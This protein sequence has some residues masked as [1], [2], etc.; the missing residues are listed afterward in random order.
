VRRV[1]FLGVL[2]SSLS[3]WADVLIDLES[4]FLKTC[5][6]QENAGGITEK[7]VRKGKDCGDVLE[8][9]KEDG[10][11]LVLPKKEV[12]AVLPMLP[13]P[14]MRYLQSDSER[15]LAV[16]KQGQKIYPQRPEVAP[17]AIAKW[18][19]LAAQKTEVDQFELSAL[20]AW[21]RSSGEISPQAK[22][23]EIKRLANEGE[24]F[25]VKFPHQAEK[26]VEQVKGLRD[27]S[28]IDLS[29]A[30]NLAFPLGSFGDNF[31]PGAILWG[32]LLIPL[33]F[34]IQGLAGTVQG[35]RERLPLAAT[36]RFLMALAGIVF[37]GVI[38]T[39][40][41]RNQKAASAESSSSNTSAQKALWLSHNM[42]EQWSDQ[43]SQR[44]TI[45]ALDW[46][47]FLLRT[48][49]PGTDDFNSLFWRLDK[50]N[51]EITSGQIILLQ[52]V[53]MKV[54]PVKFQFIFDVPSLGQAWHSAELVGAR[55]GMLPLGRFIGGFA[56]EAISHGFSL[57]R[58]GLGLD[59]GIRWMV[60]E[61][62]SLVID[63]PATHRQGPLPKENITA[64]ELAEVF[65][66]G[67]GDIYKDRYVNVEG[68]LEEVHSTHDTLG[69]GVISS[70]DPLDEFYL[71]GIKADGSR[72]RI[73]ICCKIK[74]QEKSYFLDGKGDLYFKE[75]QKKEV[76]RTS[77]T[78]A[79]SSQHS[80]GA[81]ANSPT[82]REIVKAQN[83]N[84]NQSIFRKGGTVKFYGGRI[85]SG[86]V[87]MEAVTLYD[88]QKLEGI[89][90]GETKIIWEAPKE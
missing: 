90:N 57:V 16:L 74:S 64:K 48:I 17:E 32:L 51:I 19:K 55:L 5:L 4:P 6:I 61:G 53:V 21:F 82:I 9:E 59:N 71:V 69:M 24:S 2:L 47:E 87:E 66:Q 8:F 80:G 15:A 23:E 81:G 76:E 70:P 10:A 67:F 3:L 1:F 41:S 30:A 75:Y 20:E 31:V 11:L 68:V 12:L 83:P 39:P 60:G 27:L 65:Q 84:Q 7:V 13:L 62:G 73:R 33:V 86:K 89:N 45:S 72:R 40:A 28:R 43:A 46:K 49:Q 35:F 14:D 63:V 77:K 79:L 18:E 34:I 29:K 58:S 37:L 88:C 50:P 26:I 56:L 36:L 25:A 22:Q 85:E 78:Q 52:P 44:I 54:I 38:L 42:V